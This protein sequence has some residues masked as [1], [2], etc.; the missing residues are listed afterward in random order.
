[1]K[2]FEENGVESDYLYPERVIA[3][4]SERADLRVLMPLNRNFN[5]ANLVEESHRLKDLQFHEVLVKW[6][7]LPISMSTWETVEVSL[8]HIDAM[9]PKYRT[10]EKV[11]M[12][13]CLRFLL[14]H[15]TRRLIIE[16]ANAHRQQIA[17]LESLYLNDLTSAP[18]PP[19][20]W[21]VGLILIL[22]IIKYDENGPEKE[23]SYPITYSELKPQSN[24]KPYHRSISN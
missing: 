20:D 23:N 22:S 11:P 13:H 4:S 5:H 16:L 7:G 12:D 24:L 1:M 14:P 9:L 18:V 3:E 10:Y 17:D 6:C 2:F 8:E 15:F 19:S 21:E